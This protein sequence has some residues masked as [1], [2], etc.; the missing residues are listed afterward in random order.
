MFRKLLM[1][2]TILFCFILQSTVFPAISMGGV[3]PN[4]FI[5][6]AST[7]GFMRDETEGL[8]AG[9]FCGI[10]CDVF[11]GN[12]LGFYALL[13]MMIGFING[14]FSRIFYP[15]D[16]KLPMALITLSELS[17]STVCYILLFLLNGRFNVLWY[18]MH[19]ILPELI[20]T[21]LV[22][23][24]LYPVILFVNQKLD[25][26]ERKRAQKFV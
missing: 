15:E 22:T 7:Y 19:L 24:V 18:F 2:V 1:M 13:Y 5:I 16:I 6:I 12:I 23:L 25:A 4:I 10:L 20:Y 21:I 3:V 14:K 17:F 26:F 8:L 9:F 11:Y